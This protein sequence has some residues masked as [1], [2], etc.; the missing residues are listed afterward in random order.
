MILLRFRLFADGYVTGWGWAIDNI[1]IV[2]NE[3]SGVG[4]TP[5]AVTLNQ[6]YPNPF[7]PMTTISFSRP[8]RSRARLQI[9]DARG[10]LVRTLLDE[11]LTEGP[12]SV[13]WDGKDNREQ[14]SAAGVYFYRLTAGKTVLQ[15]KMTLV[16]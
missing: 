3:I 10:R 2:S 1:D 15:D 4:D 16:K 8:A 6:N 5:H 13:V 9:F 7:N 12:H 14:T 11:Q